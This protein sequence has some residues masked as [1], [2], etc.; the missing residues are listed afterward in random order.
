M[1]LITKINSVNSLYSAINASTARFKKESGLTCN[2]G[3]GDCCLKTD[4]SAT[5]LE[6]LPAAHNLYLKGE[7][8]RILD[9][10][11]QCNDSRCVFYTPFNKRGFCLDYKNRGMICRLF[12]FSVRANKYGLPNLVTCKHIKEK[13]NAV[14]LEKTISFAPLISH[15]Y[16]K[17]FSIDPELSVKFFPINESIRR[18]LEIVL[19]HYQYRKRRA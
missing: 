2:S 17:L 16:L 15:Y 10:I 19:L 5:V 9:R 3:C 8:S 13:I 1:Q 11:E 14:Q 4:I 12:G 7:Y 18:A 6:F